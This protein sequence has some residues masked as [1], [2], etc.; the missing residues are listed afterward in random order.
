MNNLINTVQEIPK[1]K[2][3]FVFD[4]D[5]TL[6][7]SKVKID[8]EMGV[9]LA[10]LLANKKVAIIGGASFRQMASQ[11]PDSIF[12]NGNLSLLPLDGGSFYEYKNNSWKQ[13]YSQKLTDEQKRKIFK[14]FEKTFKD[15][16]YI[17]P[18]K[19]YGEL[20]EDRGSQITFS[21]LGQQA[22]LEEKEKWAEEENDK[23]LKLVARLNSYLPD[24][25]AKVA[26][27]TSID[28]TKKG[29]DKEFG[30]EQII[31]HLDVLKEDIIFFGDALESEG[32]DY[33]VLESGV[34]CFKVESVQ[35]TKNA[36]GYLLG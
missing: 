3:V 16:D 11:L 36:I 20:I 14:A 7:E 6:A 9:L 17:Q 2:S 19:I 23:R 29:I 25:K 8:S 10:R 15:I 4:L 1:G 35:N 32:N 22:P 13:V 18:A 24:M 33:P 12:K 28:V 31:K 30:I 5:G 21:A 34:A 26:G 27:L